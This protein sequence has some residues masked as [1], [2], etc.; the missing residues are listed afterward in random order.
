MIFG[1]RTEPFQKT[2][3]KITNKR[4]DTEGTSLFFCCCGSF[5]DDSLVQ[6]DPATKLRRFDVVDDEANELHQFSDVS[7]EKCFFF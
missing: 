2:G 3:N 1:S 6:N 5:V 7:S 4:N